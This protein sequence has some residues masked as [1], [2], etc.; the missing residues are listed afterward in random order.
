MSALR[1]AVGSLNERLVTADAIGKAL[2]LAGG[3]D[4]PAWVYVFRGQ[5]EAIRAAAEAL[6]LL[7]NGGAA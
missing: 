4:P 7:I 3:E 1:A 5:V 2:D 6:E